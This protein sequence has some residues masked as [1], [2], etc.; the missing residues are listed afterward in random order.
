[1]ESRFNARARF[2][3]WLEARVLEVEDAEDAEDAEDDEA[4]IEKKRLAF[5]RSEQAIRDN[6]DDFWDSA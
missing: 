1:M 3:E 2:D 6:N 5:V 4:M